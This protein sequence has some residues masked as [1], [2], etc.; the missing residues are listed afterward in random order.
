MDSG[1]AFVPLEQEGGRHQH[2]GEG[3]KEQSFP[4]EGTAVGV[5]GGAVAGPAIRIFGT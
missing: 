2:Q 3:E 5:I 4:V 1:A